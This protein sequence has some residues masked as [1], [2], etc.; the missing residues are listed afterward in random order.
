MSTLG[1]GANSFI[2]YLASSL[3]DGG[4][5][6]T[7]YLSNITTLTGETITTTDFAGF[8]IGRITIDPLSTTNMEFCSFTAVDGTNIAL[9][10]ATRGLSAVGNDVST[11][12][13]KYH[14]VGTPVIISFG[15]H[16]IYDIK[17]YID[18]EIAALT[19]GTASIVTGTAG[20]NITAGNLVY[21]KNDGK[22]WKTD[23]DTLTTID[24]V[25]LGITQSTVL[26]N[27]TITNGVLIAGVDTHQSGASAG[28]YGYVSNTAGEIGLSAGTNSYIVGQ[29][30]TATNIYFDPNFYKRL[31]VNQVGALAGKTG[32]PSATNKYLTEET[33][34]S[35][36]YLPVV[37]KYLNAAS[38]ATW[39][40]PAGLKYIIVEVQAGGGGGGG[41]A[42]PSSGSQKSGGGGGS[43][44]YS[45]RLIAVASLGTTETVTIGS[46]GSAGSGGDGGTGGNSSFGSLVTT[47]G[48]S[49][50]GGSA[51]SSSS[52]GSGGTGG[53]A[54]SG[55]VNIAG[56]DGASGIRLE[57]GTTD[58]CLGGMGGSSMLGKGGLYNKDSNTGLS[59]IGYGAGGSGGASRYNDGGRDGGVGTA[60]I[61]IVTEYYF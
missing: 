37:R 46:A 12:R 15:V 4:S 19:V 43:G 30:K 35:T 7:I 34:A 42:A 26:A 38:P 51:T 54:S 14:P 17:N 27:A 40:K 55:D 48:G 18:T 16:N 45:K 20:E 28:A 21:L 10:G 1:L 23:A 9:T 44:G 39:T 31:T 59:A 5:E 24:S 13:A 33:G 49:G 47:T 36:A 58:E 11:L 8:G 25:Q 32:T 57:A 29:F 60:G 50:G 56:Q 2:A 6:T 52:N 53:T 22:W 61:V 3:T 41:V